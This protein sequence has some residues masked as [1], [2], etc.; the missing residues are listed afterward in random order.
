MIEHYFWWSYI[1]GFIGL[2]R[3]GPGRPYQ[4]IRLCRWEETLFSAITRRYTALW[5]ERAW[6]RTLIR[7]GIIAWS[8]LWKSALD[9]GIY[10]KDQPTP[11]TSLR[12][13]VCAM[14]GW[15]NKWSSVL[16][17]LCRFQALSSFGALARWTPL[18]QL[19]FALTSGLQN[20][21]ICS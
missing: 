3:L 5:V 20:T 1:S 11:V 16:H 15:V 18:F 2:S 12:R 14:I 13:P 19:F 4:F 17:C 9:W 7:W 6:N 10:G 8:L 21:F